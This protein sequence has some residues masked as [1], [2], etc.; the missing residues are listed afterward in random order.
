MTEIFWLNWATM[1][2]SL[3]NVILLIWLGLTVLLNAERRTWGAF[4][5]GSGLMLG[6]LFFISH[7][8]I[9]A[10]GWND[11]GRGLDFWWQIGLAPVI[12][13][14]FVW[15]L[16]MLWYSGF[17]D[18]KSFRIHKRQIAWLIFTVFLS[19]MLLGL[20]VFE[21]SVPLYSDYAREGLSIANSLFQI[22]LILYIYPIYLVLCFGLAL[23]ALLH[24]G[25]SERV[26]G[27]L[28][29]KRARPWLIATSIVLLLVSLLV[30]LVLFW[31]IKFSTQ[32]NLLTSEST[33]IGIFDLTI[34]TLISFAV[35]LLGQ[36]I[37]AYEVFTGKALPR[38][39]FLRQW[40]Q[41]IF[42]AFGYGGVIGFT[43]N[44]DLR[45]IYSLLLTALLMT[46]FFAMLSWRS[47]SERERYI[48]NLRP[49]IASQG[50]FN[51]LVTPTHDSKPKNNLQIPFNGL[52][53][54]ILGT[55]MA[56]LIAVGPL[57]PLVGPPLS[58][59]EG[60]ELNAF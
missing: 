46:A 17:L 52:C 54:E 60:K 3:A 44:T 14:P 8:A 1:A 7:T 6:G 4:L 19:V 29:R 27:E 38:R 12:A 55:R 25:P 15:Y 34:E 32:Q 35:I 9:L 20:M 49:F 16:M 39:G 33:I 11:Y 56:Y 24:P 53:K 26:M 43:A 36:A 37:V 51:Q 28:A 59:P 21:N 5:A 23:D 10:Y 45:P 50:F 18:K 13:L 30:V 22:P 2:I 57:A 48:K 41:A 40:K 58:Y 31:V 42:L 47:Y